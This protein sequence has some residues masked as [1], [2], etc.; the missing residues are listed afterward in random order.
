MFDFLPDRGSSN[1]G[2]VMTF[3][4]AK[5]FQPRM[6]LAADGSARIRVFP[7]LLGNCVRVSLWQWSLL[8]WDMTTMSTSGSWF[9]DA[10]HDSALCLEMENLEC[11]NFE[12]PTSHGSRTTVKVLGD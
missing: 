8:S 5:Y 11:K 4:G 1:L 7:P 10:I 3:S 9:R 6:T 12:G 2:R